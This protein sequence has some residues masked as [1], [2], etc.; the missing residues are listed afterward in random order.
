M[1]DLFRSRQK[2][3]RYMLGG[4]LMVI[5]VS[6]VVT[7]IPG[8]GSSGSNR[9]DDSSVIAAIGG[10]KIT[11]RGAAQQAQRILRGNQ[12]PPDMIDVYMPQ[13]IDQM[14]QQ[15]AL[16]YEFA[17]IGVTATDQE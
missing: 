12:I 10:T 17:R 3:V 7:L 16:T 2:A 13:F 1:F 15:R 8:Y 4:I 11:G 14:I 9:N 5:A 6:M